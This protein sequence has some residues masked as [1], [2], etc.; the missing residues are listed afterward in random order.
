VDGEEYEDGDDVRKHHS[1]KSRFGIPEKVEEEFSRLGE[2]F[3][4][5]FA[6]SAWLD[7]LSIYTESKM[8][9]TPA[10]RHS[11]LYTQGQLELFV[12]YL[13]ASIR[14]KLIRSLCYIFVLLA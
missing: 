5:L 7:L 4:D 13:V 11:L 14:I 8:R 2:G 12:A 10:S 1:D 9:Q 3:R 6:S